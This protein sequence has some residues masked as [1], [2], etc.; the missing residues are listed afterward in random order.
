MNEQEAIAHGYH[1]A[2]LDLTVVLTDTLT[3]ENF[4][5]VREI[6]DRMQHNEQIRLATDFTLTE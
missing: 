5:L 3:P 6:L 1:Y 4:K 2:M